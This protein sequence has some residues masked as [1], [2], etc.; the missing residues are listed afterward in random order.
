VGELEHKSTA[1]NRRR[2]VALARTLCCALP[3][4][5]ALDPQ[6][7]A[8][9]SA[10][11]LAL[12][13]AVHLQL[14]PCPSAQYEAAEL[15]E[16]LRVELRGLGVERLEVEPEGAESPSTGPLALIHVGCGTVKSTL[17]IDVADM[18]SGNRVSRE[19]VVDDV[20]TTGRARALSIAIASLLESSWSILATRPP[21]VAAHSGPT[22]MPE[23]VRVALRRRLSSG[24]AQPAAA[25]D[26]EL[27]PVFRSPPVPPATAPVLVLRG[28]L[29][30]RA[31][32]SRASGLTGLDIG[33]APRL[34]Q[35]LELVFDV[36]AMYG[37]QTL[38]DVSISAAGLETLWLS[39]GATLYFET[40]TEPRLLLGPT[41]RAAYVHLLTT[42]EDDN[43]IAT[44]AGGWILLIGASSLLTFDLSRA[45]G[46]FLGLDIGYVP[47]GLSFRTTNQHAISF[48]DLALAFRFGVA[49]G[50]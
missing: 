29:L 48:A 30:A 11:D 32:P 22:P 38:R 39:A 37:R 3:A 27:P 16:L 34:S 44:D 14:N 41:L 15:A 13:N 45:C 36:E 40:H 10:S 25:Q 9:Q 4:V 20:A 31:F 43:F 12:P 49:Y 8:A 18:L 46:V 26:A 5:C 24:F 23:N 21:E 50:N 1:R 17:A 28:S 2:I 47:G 6:L 35:Y 19:I 33:A 42:I 7:A